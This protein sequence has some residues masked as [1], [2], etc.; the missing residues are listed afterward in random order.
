MG[1][2]RTVKPELYRHEELFDAEQATGLPLRLSFTGLLTCCDREGRFKWQPRS[3][4]VD[5]LPYDDLDFAQVLE[6]LCAAG[7]IGRYTAEDKTYG[8]IPSWHNHQ[9]INIREPA[10]VLPDPFKMEKPPITEKNTPPLAPISSRGLCLVSAQPTVDPSAA[11]TVFAHWKH[12][13][14][15]PTAVLD[16]NRRLWIARALKKGYSAAELCQAIT[17][18]FQT[19]YNRGQN[20]QGQ[21][22]YGLHVILRDA[23][24]IERF[25]RH[26]HYPPQT[27]STSNTCLAGNIRAAK[28]WLD[29][30]PATE[31]FYDSTG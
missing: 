11:E 30:N 16:S 4:K 10:S 12:T 31:K 21:S 22:Y 23:D 9:R 29:N 5:I 17:G 1:R 8:Y 28:Q 2:I 14:G 15:H 6:A 25:I 26:C 13:F 18:C 20:A 7:F 19:P 24:Q 3:L 27:P